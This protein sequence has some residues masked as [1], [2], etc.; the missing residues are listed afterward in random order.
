MLKREFKPDEFIHSHLC[1][2]MWT[3]SITG[4]VYYVEF[5]DEIIAYRQIYFLKVRNQA[6]S[7]FKE[8][9]ALVEYETKLKIRRLKFDNGRDYVIKEFEDYLRKKRILHE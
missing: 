2:P 1:G 9:C 6:S 4:A 8:F 5:K 7:K 3:K